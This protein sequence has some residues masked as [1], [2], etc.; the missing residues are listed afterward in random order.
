MNKKIEKLIQRYPNIFEWLYFVVTIIWTIYI[1]CVRYLNNN[2]GDNVE[3][4]FFVVSK[5]AFSQLVYFTTIHDFIWIYLQINKYS[6]NKLMLKIKNGV[7][8]DSSKQIVHFVNHFLE[9]MGIRYIPRINT[10]EN[11]KCEVEKARNDLL[12]LVI[13]YMHYWPNCPYYLTKSQT[14]QSDYYVY[15]LTASL[16]EED[17]AVMRQYLIKIIERIIEENKW[18]C[19]DEC[20][21]IPFL[22]A[23]QNRNVILAEKVS[24]ELIYD[25]V[26]GI[27]ILLYQ[28]INDGQNCSCGNS[29][30]EQFYRIYLGCDALKEKIEKTVLAHLFCKEVVLH[31]I[32]I[33]CNV[34]E[35]TSMV[36]LLSD[37]RMEGDF[38][39]FV[40][41][42]A[43]K[44]E[45]SEQCGLKP[46]QL[47]FSPITDCATLFIASDQA[48]LDTKSTLQQNFER[49]GL[50]LWY[51]FVLPES[52]KEKLW[53]TKNKLKEDPNKKIDSELKVILAWKLKNRVQLQKITEIPNGWIYIDKDFNKFI[54][55]LKP[56]MQENK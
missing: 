13:D 16:N 34:T 6:M 29:K 10:V 45:F 46:N 51:Y 48:L 11:Y 28:P 32:L 15:T 8:E 19:N 33:D 43:F 18:C 12:K 47:S 56:K 9:E 35:G 49:V 5:K 25:N 53:N 20:C 7:N 17:L 52:I 23:L 24:D 1:L 39:T 2:N 21:H 55:C 44:K 36:N 22:I 4:L 26:K 50:N 54:R 30:F 37:N 14:I 42:D 38:K 31:G 3:L 41:N 27:P 40:S